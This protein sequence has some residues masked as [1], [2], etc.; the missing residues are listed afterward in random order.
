MHVEIRKPARNVK[1]LVEKK[2]P[3]G[4]FFFEPNHRMHTFLLLLQR[5]TVIPN[6]P[7]Y[8]SRIRF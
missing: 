1:T 6:A 2:R 4:R 8:R 5:G 7:T 3:T